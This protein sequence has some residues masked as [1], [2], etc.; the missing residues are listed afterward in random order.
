[1]VR[2]DTVMFL[3]HNRRTVDGQTYEYRTLV[4]TVRIAKGPRQKVVASLG[5]I[6]GLDQRTRH[7]WDSIS[8]LLEG[9]SPTQQGELGRA[10]PQEPRPHPKGCRSVTR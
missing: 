4:R 5:R 7:G 2:Q 8:D 10:S 1:M 9:R 3:R 6:P